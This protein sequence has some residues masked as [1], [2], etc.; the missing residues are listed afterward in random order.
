MAKRKTQSESHTIVWKE[1]VGIEQAIALKNELLEAFESSKK[2]Y[3]DLSAV[4]DIDTSAIQLILSAEK[5][6]ERRSVPFSV[7]NTVPESVSAIVSLLNLTL[8][9]TSETEKANA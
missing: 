5:E 4:E 6:G 1:S 9:I 2:I 3:L 7:L 8:P